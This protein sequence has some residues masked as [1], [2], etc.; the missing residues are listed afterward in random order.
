MLKGKWQQLP[1]SQLIPA[2]WNYKTDDLDIKMRLQASLD[3][4]GLIL[5]CIVR[6]VPGGFEVID[7]NHRLV[8]LQETHQE[9]VWCY[10]FGNI[11]EDV[12]QRIAVE[13]NDTRFK[14]DSQKLAGIVVDIKQ[15]IKDL[16]RILDMEKLE[17]SKQQITLNIWIDAK[18]CAKWKKFVKIQGS[19]EEALGQLLNKAMV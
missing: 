16:N 7:G 5:N 2:P 15:Q 13:I 17:L 4:N 1:V 9:T 8:W 14:S 19:D 11:S 10:N 6:E 12:A 18:S 3:D